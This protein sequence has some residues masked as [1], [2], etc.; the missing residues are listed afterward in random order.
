MSFS[1][2]FIGAYDAFHP[3]NAV[4]LTGL[5]QAGVEIHEFKVPISD[6]MKSA[7]V[8]TVTI[9][10]KAAADAARARLVVELQA[11]ENLQLDVLF[12]AYPGHFLVPFAAAVAKLRGAKLVFDPLVSL[13]DTFAVDLRLMGDQSAAARALWATD[14]TSMALPDL[15][16]ADTITHARFFRK[17]FGVIDRRLA[18]VPVGA[19]PVSE[20]TGA[21]RDLGGDKPM[22]VFMH[23]DWSPLH[24]AAAVL[25]AAEALRDQGVRFDL[26]GEGELSGDLRKQIESR[27]LGNVEWL[28]L[29]PVHELRERTLAADVCLGLFGS[30]EKV[31]RLIPEHAYD[32]LACGRP[33]VTRESPAARE[34]LTD[35]ETALLVPPA[36]GVALTEALRRLLVREERARMGAAALALYRARLMPAAIAD[37]LLEALEAIL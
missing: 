13:S 29:M 19:L 36:D 18:V 17:A 3:R 32:A 31:A 6:A 33:L 25:D 10:G 24:G 9:L 28:G 8:G 22:R 34:L 21:A 23:G 7:D 11:A 20:A 2:G 14:K 1:V 30:S 27:K 37:R 5:R 16:L 15:V 26:A 4:L 35:T 12:V